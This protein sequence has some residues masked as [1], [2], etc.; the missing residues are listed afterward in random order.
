MNRRTAL[1]RLDAVRPGSDDLAL[2]ELAEAAALLRRDP[3]IAADF[4][5]RQDWDAS[6]ATALRDV[7]VPAHLRQ[8]LRAALAARQTPERATI[9]MT[10]RAW[11][12]STGAAAAG[13]MAAAGWWLQADRDLEPVSLAELRDASADLLS[14]R[15]LPT[16]FDGTFTPIV[17]PGWAARLRLSPQTMGVLPGAGGRHRAAAIGLAA[18]GRWPVRGVLLM[19]PA[20]AVAALPPAESIYD[21]DY[22][23]ADATGGETVAW[24]ADGLAY[25]CRVDGRLDDLLRHLEVAPA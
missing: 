3:A 8:S 2:P 9:P 17:P 15:T 25:I 19:S 12:V 13:L 1:E 21:R 23:P 14:G 22:L 7:P 20:K 4:R 24:T 5:R 16:A 10:R 11:L 6:I 18:G